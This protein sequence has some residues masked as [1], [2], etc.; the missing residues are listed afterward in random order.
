MDPVTI[1][2]DSS[3][4][5]DAPLWLG[6]AQPVITVRR[7]HSAHPCQRRVGGR[8]LLAIDDKGNIGAAQ[9]EIGE[10]TVVEG[11]E[12][13]KGSLALAPGRETLSKRAV[14]TEQCRHDFGLL[15]KVQGIGSR[16]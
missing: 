8:A 16:C 7:D 6:R 13:R 4:G 9:A 3:P 12:L 5:P 14:K 2:P 10:G 15:H 1:S 11:A